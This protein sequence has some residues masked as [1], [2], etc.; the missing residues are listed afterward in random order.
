MQLKLRNRINC[1]HLIILSAY[2]EAALEADGG[3]DDAELQYY[4]G[5]SKQNLV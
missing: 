2:N 5:T 3:S 4:H 1:A